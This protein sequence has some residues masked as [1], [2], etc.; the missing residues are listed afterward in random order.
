[1]TEAV[2]KQITQLRLKGLGYKSISKVIGASRETVKYYCK[3]H[4]L[5]GNAADV[6]IRYAERRRNPEACKQ[7]GRKLVRTGHSGKKLFCTEKCRRDWWKEHPEESVKGK[8]SFYNFQCA[9]CGKYFTVY[10][11]KRRKYCS[12]DCYIVDR[13]WKGPNKSITVVKTTSRTMIGDIRPRKG[14]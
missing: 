6:K 11:N 12:H 1:M 14:R 5:D 13:F 9:G 10:G 7:C 2:G 8:D 3:T 4:G